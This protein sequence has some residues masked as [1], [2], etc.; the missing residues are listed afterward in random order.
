[1]ALSI[2]RNR[3]HF[4]LKLRWKRTQP[5]EDALDNQDG[6]GR[7]NYKIDVVLPDTKRCL[8]YWSVCWRFDRWLSPKGWEKK[9]TAHSGFRRLSRCSHDSVPVL[10]GGLY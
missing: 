9:D 10:F 2:I 5:N 7:R 8:Q 3:L 6:L 4:Q 1:M